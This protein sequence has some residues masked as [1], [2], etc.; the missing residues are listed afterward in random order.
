M[1]SLTLVV[2][3]VGNSCPLRCDYCYNSDPN[4]RQRHSSK[5]MSPGV[6]E[7]ML[8]EFFQVPQRKHVI[9]WH[10]GEPTVAGI[11]FYENVLRLQKEMVERFGVKGKV[12]NRIQTSGVLI[13]EAW[14]EFLKVSGIKPGFSVDGP[15]IVHDAHRFYPD[16][17]GSLSDTMSGVELLRSRGVR[18]GAGAVINKDSLEHPLEVFEFLRSY[19]TGFDFSPCFETVAE[20]S[21][22]SYGISAKEYAS[23]VKTVFLHWWK[24]DDPTIRV[25]SF[26]RY[27]EA[28]LGK[29]PKVCSM[30]SGCNR[31]LS[32]DGNG[33]VYPCGRF[34]GLP[35]L[36]LGNITQSSFE[37]I[38]SSAPYLGY[39]G[40]A[41][42]MPEE[43]QNCRWKF[44]CNN[45]CTALRYTEQGTFL[46]K[47]PLCE[48]N[49]DILD[50]V[51]QLVKE[52]KEEEKRKN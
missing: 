13:D 16:G 40:N 41:Q 4:L 36:C 21:I 19:F 2:K 35:E 47:S 6:L 32:V 5:T 18:I 22:P 31:F 50:F 38:R 30:S 7:K 3:P 45:G 25:K 12:T 44:A 20:G 9:I 1:A 42:Y 24:I 26:V 43:C 10:G 51:Q 48:A 34:A 37:D 46:P 11:S 23:F 14:A 17:R 39:L 33:D 15:S 28:A 52:T 49:L 27:V 8:F 29:A